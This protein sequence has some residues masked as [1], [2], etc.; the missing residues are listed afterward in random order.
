M[1]KCNPVF[2]VQEYLLIQS[3]VR[4]QRIERIEWE[5]TRKAA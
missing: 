5:G 4:P 3:M 2:I 1:N